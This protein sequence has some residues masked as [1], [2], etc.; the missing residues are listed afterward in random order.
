MEDNRMNKEEAIKRGL[1]LY[2]KKECFHIGYCRDCV[3]YLNKK[4]CDRCGK[5]IKKYAPLNAIP[6]GGKHSLPFELRVPAK[7]TMKPAELCIDCVQSF[8]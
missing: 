5:P 1:C 2:D 6:I 7:F 3:V 8:F 4:A